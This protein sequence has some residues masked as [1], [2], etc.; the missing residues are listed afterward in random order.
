MPPSLGTTVIP[1]GYE[2][3]FN[4]AAAESGADLADDA[5]HL[6]FGWCLGVIDTRQSKLI[7]MTYGF[8]RSE[9]RVAELETRC[10]ELE[11]CVLMSEQALLEARVEN[12]ILASRVATLA[13]S[14]EAA[15][16]MARYVIEQC[17]AES[18]RE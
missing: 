13:C 17:A 7:A 12:E 11:E 1:V 3:G 15:V 8:H 10:R 14:E 9:Q 6:F 16:H 18:V 4:K 2:A 5:M